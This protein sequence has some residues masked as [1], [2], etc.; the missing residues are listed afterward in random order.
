MWGAA[1]FLFRCARCSGTPVWVR[2]SRSSRR[3]PYRVAVPPEGGGAPPALGGRRAAP[4][5]PQ[6]RWV[7]GG[8]GWGGRPP[9]RSRACVGGGGGVGGGLW[10]PGDASCRP[11]GGGAGAWQSWPRGPAIGRGVAPS[12]RPPL[13]RAG[14]SRRPSLGPLIPR[15][16][17]RGAGRPGVAVRVSGQWLAGCRAAGS[18]PRLLSPHSLPREVA[19]RFPWAGNKAGVTGVVLS[20][21]GVAPHTTP[22]RAHPASLGTICAASRCAVVG[23][24]VLRGRHVSRRL[25]RGGGSHSGSP[26][27]RGGSIPLPR[28]VGPGPPRLAGWWGGVGGGGCRAAASLLSFRAAACGTPFWLSPCRRR[29]PFRRARA[30]GA[31]VPPRGGRG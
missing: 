9:A 15:L 3:C 7:R 18:P 21:G 12:P 8:G 27:G 22:V 10:S 30:V 13:P 26:L 28:G 19:R 17:S 11:G 29:A 25:G 4:V 20:T 23:P 24:L 2:G 6:L 31:E 14:F 16:L 5:A 1:P